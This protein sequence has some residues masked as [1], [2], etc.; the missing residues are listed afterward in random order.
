MITVSK[1]ISTH[2]HSTEFMCK[3]GCR[4][5]KIDE[6]L[7]NKM[8]N[9]FTK[10][11]ASKCIISSGYRCP[12]YDKRIGGFV[13]RHAEGLAADCIYYDK[14]GKPIPSKYVIC[15][16]YDLKE[17]NGIAKINDN[18]THLDNRSSGSYRGDET[19]SNNSVWTNP[20]DY[21]GVSRSDMAKYTGEVVTEGIDVFYKVKTQKHGWLSEVKNLEDYAGFE[22]SPIIGLAIK[23]S[24][25]RIR[26]R[27]HILGGDWLPWV[28]DY[29]I[30][31]I[32]EGYAG[33]D[34]PIDAVQVYYY[35]P[36]DVRPYK[37]AK[38]K[39]NNYDWQHD[40]ETMKGQDGFAGVFGVVATKFQITIE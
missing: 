30:K 17:L 27:V 26:Y 8:E 1:Q 33:N 20:Y 34:K 11:N 7:V 32:K 6:N 37:K 19:V 4:K 40:E 14:E 35:T 15:A 2:F 9:I 39:V 5:I 24:K 29:D 23:T 31:D 3:C 12:E 21:F 16:A 18:Y 36:D 25:G 13:G 10:L 38:Y 22:D 28:D